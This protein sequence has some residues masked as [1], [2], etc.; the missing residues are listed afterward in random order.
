[1]PVISVRI[2]RKAYEKLR[3]MASARS[4]GVSTVAKEIIVWFLENTDTLTRLKKDLEEVKKGLEELKSF[5]ANF[6]EVC[7]SWCKEAFVKALSDFT[8]ELIAR[9]VPEDT[10]IAVLESLRRKVNQS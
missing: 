5:G 4:A 3:M 7:S 1:M 9:A 10:V 6:M 2:D 8:K